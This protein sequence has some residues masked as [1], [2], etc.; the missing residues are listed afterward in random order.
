MNSKLRKSVYGCLVARA[1]TF[2]RKQALLELY[3]PKPIPDAKGDL[4]A[5]FLDEIYLQ[6]FRFVRAVPREQG[7]R[8][9]VDEIERKH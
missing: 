3:S 7:K 2:L 4:S 6:N 5:F 1:R 8:G 9:D